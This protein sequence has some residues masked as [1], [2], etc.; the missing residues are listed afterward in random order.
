[1][2]RANLE[3]ASSMC[4]MLYTWI[5][6]TESYQFRNPMNILRTL[7]YLLRSNARAVT[8]S[9]YLGISQPSMHKIVEKLEGLGWIER[10]GW[11]DTEDSLEDRR[12]QRIRL[13]TEGLKLMNT[14][15]FVDAESLGSLVKQHSGRDRRCI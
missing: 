11:A 3:N 6:Q 1:M 13:S 12:S 9:R 4:L 15:G 2:K 8:L 5:E 7:L 10:E 14:V